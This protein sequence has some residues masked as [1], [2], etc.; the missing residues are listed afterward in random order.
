MN[1]KNLKETEKYAEEI[2]EN[3]GQKKFI[4]L[5]GEVGSGKT[6][7]VKF[8]GKAL[9]EEKTITSPTFNFMKVYDKFVHIDAYKLNGTLEEFEDYFEDKIV[10]I[11][12]W[13][14]LSETFDN[15]L[16]IKIE[17]NKDKRIYKEEH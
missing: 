7:L 8:L 1:S 13:K 6:T 11:E 4:L 3:L 17:I 10:I 16:K 15:P 2:I 9:G 5:D 12:W 14:N